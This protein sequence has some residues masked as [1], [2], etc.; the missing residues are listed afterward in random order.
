[1]PSSFPADWR[2]FLLP[3]RKA[4]RRQ[5]G[6]QALPSVRSWSTGGESGAGAAN[7]LGAAARGKMASRKKKNLGAIVWLRDHFLP[8]VIRGVGIA[9]A[10]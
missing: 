6:P 8:L 2:H 3:E 7:Q 9:L 4:S 5:A 1:M 10:I